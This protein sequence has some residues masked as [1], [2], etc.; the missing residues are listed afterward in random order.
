MQ[1]QMRAASGWRL[2]LVLL[3]GLSVTAGRVSAQDISIVAKLR[4]GD[5]FQLEVIRI[6]QNSAQPQQNGNS[7]TPVNVLVLSTSTDGSVL[8]WVPGAT[9]FDNPQAARD[10]LVGSVAQAL[11]D[12]GLQLNLNAAGKLVGLVNQA[13]VALKVKAVVDAVVRDLAARMPQDQRKGFL[14]RIG[15]VLSVDVLIAS[16][17]RDAATYLA[18]N[19]ASL[20]VG[21]AVIVDVEQSTPL[22]GDPIPAKFHMQMESASSDVTSLKTTTTYDAVALRRFTRS[23]AEQAGSR[24]PPEQ[25]AK[26][27]PMQM[28]D[29][30]SY[31]FDRK[32]GLMR[33]VKVNRRVTVGPNRRLDGWEIRL[34]DAR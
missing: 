26:L 1:Q 7:T 6:R 29:E 16:A 10:P 12:I 28:A 21:Q 13:E 19:G 24:I 8:E 31:V 14:D 23:L 17:T 32:R 11:R 15:K 2:A 4:A 27:P 22:G 18:L 34:I 33:E 25:L 5:S 3:V 30:G 20:A 9:V